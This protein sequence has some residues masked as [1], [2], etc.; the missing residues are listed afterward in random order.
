MKKII[1]L[2]ILGMLLIAQTCLATET[3]SVANAPTS[4]WL[5][6]VIN[7]HRPKF[8]CE[9]G[10][11]ICFIFSWGIEVPTGSN[12]NKLCI[13]RGQYN[14]QNQ[15][16][17]EVEEAALAKYED[18]STLPY[19]K[20]KKSITIMDPYTFPEP[21]CRALGSAAP[22]TIQPG[23]YPVTYRNGTYTIVFQF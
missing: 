4:I 19:F 8:K 20:D 7:F 10:F 9:S 17:L 16:V 18:G 3:K 5:K 14:D 12:D 23:S 21:T 15:F 1:L 22:I 2:S 11:S 6:L 13:G